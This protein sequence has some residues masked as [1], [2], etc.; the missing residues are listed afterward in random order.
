MFLQ[1]FLSWL[2]HYETD[3]PYV[4]RKCTVY[5]SRPFYSDL[6]FRTVKGCD[7]MLA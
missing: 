7:G 4:V 6:V 5:A 2:R 1:T 3:S